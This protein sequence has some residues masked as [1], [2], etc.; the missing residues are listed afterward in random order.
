MRD[1]WRGIVLTYWELIRIVVPVTIVTEWLVRLGV[2]DA[3]APWL[4]PVMT[5]FGLDGE[6]AFAWI[7]ALL[8]GIWAGVAVLFTVVPVESLTSAD[9]TVLSTLFLFAHAL[10]VEQLIIRRLG[11]GFAVT[12]LLRIVGGMIYAWILHA[13]F[14]VTGWLSQPVSPAWSPEGSDTGWVGFFTGL[15]E[16]LVAMFVIL[17]IVVWLLEGLKALGFM[18]RLYVL[19]T[20]LFRLSGIRGRVQPLLAVGLLLGIGYGGGLLI[21]EARQQ[22]LD[23]RQVLLCCVFM[24][25]SHAIIE[26]TLVVLAVG[27]DLTAVLV[28]RLLFTFVATA[29]F[30]A[31]IARLSEPVLSRWFFTSPARDTA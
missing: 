18:D 28:G 20:P 7:S 19:L 8:I 26:D 22:R 24:G 15:A 14:S 2:I 6:L 12:S 11:P 9:V 5:T 31:L 10:P 1:I 30:A 23:R 16:T 4:A 27:A 3:L 29:L 13:I 21:N 17:V 25:F